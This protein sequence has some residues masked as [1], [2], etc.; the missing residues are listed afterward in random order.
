MFT[1]KGLKNWFSSSHWCYYA[2]LF[3]KS[4]IYCTFCYANILF[5]YQAPNRTLEDRILQVNPL[6]EAFGNAKTGINDNSSRFGKYLEMTFTANGKITGACLSE[7][8]LEKSRVISQA[9][10]LFTF[11]VLEYFFWDTIYYGCAHFELEARFWKPVLFAILL[12]FLYYSV[13]QFCITVFL[14]F[15]EHVKYFNN[16]KMFLMINNWYEINKCFL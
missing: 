12:A 14:N 1:D 15:A 2:W 8:L 13:F 4:V 7:Y 16:F 3:L 10:L 5:C 9:R 6:L 11:Y